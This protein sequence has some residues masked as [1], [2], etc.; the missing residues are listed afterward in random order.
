M[1]V[2]RLSGQG[3]VHGR[4]GE[5]TKAGSPTQRFRQGDVRRCGAG[6]VLYPGSTRDRLGPALRRPAQASSPADRSG[7]CSRRTF[8]VGRSPGIAA[9]REV[10]RRH[11]SPRSKPFKIEGASEIRRTGLVA[12][13]ATAAAE[14]T[15]R[16]IRQSS[17]S[18][19]RWVPPGAAYLADIAAP[20]RRAD[21]GRGTARDAHRRSRPED[22]P[23]IVIKWL[24]VAPRA[25]AK[26]LSFCNG[27]R[28]PDELDSVPPAVAD[29]VVGRT[30][31]LDCGFRW[32]RLTVRREPRSRVLDRI[33]RQVGSGRH[34]RSLSATSTT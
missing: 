29:E 14:A 20:P 6:P 17:G 8:H 2:P 1:L 26:T 12:T 4:S 9:S 10:G 16:G 21:H 32:C 13:R 15:V 23:M 19:P 27:A 22:K 18:A 24:L 33:H 28:A 5:A 11:R 25:G 31:A 30:R 3:Q 34:Y 7:P